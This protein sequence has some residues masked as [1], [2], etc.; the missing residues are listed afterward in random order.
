[1]SYGFIFTAISVA[2]S[3]TVY[4]VIG[5]KASRSK[6]VTK[7]KSVSSLLA[8]SI[9]MGLIIARISLPLNVDF[10]EASH[11]LLYVESLVLTL[12]FCSALTLFIVRKYIMRLYVNQILKPITPVWHEV[13]ADIKE[14]IERFLDLKMHLKQDVTLKSMAKVLCTNRTY[15]S[16]YI[17]EVY[18]MSFTEWLRNLRLDHA[19]YLM[20]TESIHTPLKTIAYQCGF[21]DHGAMNSAFKKRHGVSPGKWR[22]SI[23]GPRHKPYDLS[24]DSAS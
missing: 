11:R 22:E 17:N 24:K 23:L 2:L 5:H 14:G 16:A 12:I 21:R 8:A 9:A 20:M 19:E 18:K 13:K 4:S 7:F 3:L 6:F 1:M 15:L 10:S